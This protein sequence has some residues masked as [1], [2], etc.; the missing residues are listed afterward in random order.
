MRKPVD[1]ANLVLALLDEAYEKKT[2]HGPNLKQSIKGVTAKQ[3]ARSRAPGGL[4]RCYSL[5]GLLEVR[6]MPGFLLVGLVEQ[7]EH[8]VCGIHRLPH[9]AVIIGARKA[10]RA[11]SF[12]STPGSLAA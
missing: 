1:S 11:R 3:A 5:D 6:S 4:L 2:W 12:V 8:Q 7:R 10:W 9:G